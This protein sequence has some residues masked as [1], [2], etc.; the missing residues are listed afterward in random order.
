MKLYTIHYFRTET[1]EQTTSFLHCYDMVIATSI[2]EA[3]DKFI[4]RHPDTPFTVLD[5]TIDIDY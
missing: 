1:H 5:E 4:E 2:K 3:G